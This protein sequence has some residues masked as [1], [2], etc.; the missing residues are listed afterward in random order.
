MDNE[1]QIFLIAGA[2]FVG[3]FLI[4]SAVILFAFVRPWMRAFMS[5]A[6]VS[7]IS[8][9]GMRLRQS[10]VSLLIDAYLQLRWNNVDA[11]IAEVERCYMQNSNRI[12]TAQDLVDLVLQE[13]DR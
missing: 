5:G 7:L 6:P 11:T 2:V 9:V 3:L 10:P 1:T 4:F 8:I 12:T 13:R